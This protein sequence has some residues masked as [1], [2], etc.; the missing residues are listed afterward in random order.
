[1]RLHGQQLVDSSHGSSTE[2]LLET[3]EVELQVLD[4]PAAKLD[5]GIA[6]AFRHNWRVAPSDFEHFRCHVDTD[7]PP[8]GTD[9]LG[10]DKANFPGAATEIENRFARP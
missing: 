8:P 10:S 1:M 6:Q 9:R 7:Y 5:I 3:I 2:I 4:A